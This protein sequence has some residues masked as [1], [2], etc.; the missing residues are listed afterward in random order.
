M[1]FSLCQVSEWMSNEM[2]LHLYSGDIATRLDLI[3]KVRGLDQAE[4]YF[5]SI[6]DTSRDFK[7]YGA[8][9]NC[10]AQHTS[11]E[12]AEAIM[13]KMEVYASKHAVDIVMSYNVMLKL[14]TRIGEHEKLNALMKEMKEK[15]IYNTLTLT[16]WLKAYVT[17]NDIDEMEKLLA[18]MEADPQATVDWFTYTSAANCYIKSGQFEKSLAML[19]KS[20]QL[21]ERKKK[22]AAYESLLT[23]YA[24]I[25]KKDDVYRIWNMCKNLVSSRNS[26]YI[27][28]LTALV[29]LNDIDGAERI[30]EQWEF[31]NTCFDFTIPNVMMSAY[32]NN[33]LLEKAEAYV[34]RLLKGHEKLDGSIWD[35]LARGYYKW[36]DMDKAVETMNKAI[37]ASRQRWK[38]CT[39][40]LAACIDH[41][42]DKGDLELALEILRI[43]RER[44]HFSAATHD[45]LLSY[46]HGEVPETNALNLMEGDYH[47]K[48]ME[49][50]SMQKIK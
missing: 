21:I 34:E 36:N 7:V 12:K 40:T 50:S 28:M 29:K 41:V 33:G 10:Y 6:R 24:A 15:N 5:S 38:P 47:P 14:Y 32:C 18:Q 49:R 30:L 39:F 1:P 43:C 9:L 37:L 19:K 45:R 25:G 48:K 13:Q 4:Q 20:E 31:G 27:S 22:R 23:M 17:S 46:V 16:I 42:K 2:N 3:G 8:L 26:H 44:S 11:V 35:C